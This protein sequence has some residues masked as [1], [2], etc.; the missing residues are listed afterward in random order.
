MNIH[1]ILYNRHYSEVYTD[2]DINGGAVLESDYL[3]H[4][5]TDNISGKN[6]GYWPHY[7]F[8]PSMTCTD[9][10]LSLGN[11][12]SPNTFF[13]MDYSH[14]YFN[15]GYKSG[16]FNTICSIHIG[17]LT[18]DKEGINAYKLNDVGQFK[19]NINTFVV[20]LERR[21]DR[22]QN[23][24]NLFKSVGITSYS[25]F[26]AVDGKSLVVTNE[27]INLFK[28]NDFSNRRG[29]IG[30]ALSHYKL[31]KQ[32]QSDKV[33]DYY[34]IYEDDITISD[35]ND[36]IRKLENVKRNLVGKDVVF[37][38]YSVRNKDNY[39]LL[40]TNQ[41]LVELDKNIYIGGFFSYIITKSGCDKLLSY[42]EKN[43]IK[44]GIDYLIKISDNLKIYNTQPSLVFSEWVQSSNSNIE[45][46][47]VLHTDTP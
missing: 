23:I 22:R 45:N 17:K 46:H 13:E 18:S 34:L 42:I 33:N 19:N 24:E 11:Y 7:S 12:D 6:C 2:L 30:C 21:K 25:F 28:G 38:G 5:K 31:W 37:L 9:I 44:H 20:N 16:F 3:I 29:V 47:S 41:D 1:Q 15:K 43:G 8:R 14:K 36:Y 10:I 39:R 27:I 40:E 35:E 32:L 26:T 4:L